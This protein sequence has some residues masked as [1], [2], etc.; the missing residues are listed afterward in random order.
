MAIGVGP[1]SKLVDSEEEFI[2]FLGGE[3]GDFPYPLGDF[4]LATLLDRA[5]LGDPCGGFRMLH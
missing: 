5:L 3:E 4:P 2:D 1:S